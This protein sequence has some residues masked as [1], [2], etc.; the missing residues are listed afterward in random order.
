[1]GASWDDSCNILIIGNVGEGG[2]LFFYFGV[3]VEV[4]FPIPAKHREGFARPSLP[5]REYGHIEAIEDL[6]YIGSEVVKNLSLGFEV[7]HSFVEFGLDVRE[8]I[9]MNL[10]S[11]F[12]CS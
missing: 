5:V 11:L 8:L 3:V 9:H 4:I 2:A 1:M 6:L 7:I 10:N 12:L